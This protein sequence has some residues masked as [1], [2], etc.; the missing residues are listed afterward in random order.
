MDIISLVKEKEKEIIDFRRELHKIPELE[1]E[2]PNTMNFIASILDKYE[3]PY[4]KYL[5]G[6]AIVAQIEGLI[7]EADNGKNKK[8]FAIRCDSDGLPVKEE[9]GLDF[10]SKNGNMHAC[11]HDGHTAIG[12]V[13]AIILNE[14][15]DKFKGKV[16]ILFQPGEETPGGAEPMIKEG[17]LEDVDA[18]IGQHMGCLFN[19]P[20]GSIG[21]KSGAIMA[22]ADKFKLIVKGVSTHAATPH[23]GQDTILCASEIVCALQKIISREIDP[24]QN[25]VLSLGSINGGTAHNVIPSEVTIQGTVRTLNEDTRIYISKRIKEISEGIALSNN[26][27]A[28][29]EYNFMYPVVVNDVEFTN[30]FVEVMEDNFGKGSVFKITEPSM[31]GEDM[32]YFLQKVKGCFF[33]LRNPK[34]HTDGTIYP[35]HNSKFDLDE[36]Q[37]YKG[38]VAFIAIAFKFLNS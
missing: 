31:G 25:A 2:L 27:K 16:K 36:T 30:M 37:F 19:M 3:V 10:A 14:N 1:L 8:C 6:N 28:V 21:V 24:L 13:T 7:N 17:V 32:A 4:S 18:I 12:L 9:T 15:R 20:E 11:G 5:N 23:K 29:V 26:C 38:V 35:H 33:M 22:S 34:I